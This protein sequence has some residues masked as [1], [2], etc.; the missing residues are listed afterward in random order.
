VSQSLLARG[1]PQG[2]LAGLILVM[3]LSGLTTEGNLAAK[4]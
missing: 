3:V 4:V 1:K 2:R